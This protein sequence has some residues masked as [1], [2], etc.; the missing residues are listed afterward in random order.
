VWI[1]GPFEP[2]I[3][4]DVSIF[5]SCLLV[6]LEDG[7]RVEADDGYRGAALNYVKCPMS[8]GHHPTTDTRST[9]QSVVRRR[10]ETRP[11]E[12]TESSIPC[13]LDATWQRLSICRNRHS[14]CY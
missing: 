5:Q 12:Y 6:M 2:G 9:M 10:Q 4:N 3:L 13:G 7:E 8:M 1:N 14:T 11:V